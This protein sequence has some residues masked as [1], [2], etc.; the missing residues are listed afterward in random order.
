MKSILNT[1][2][3]AMALLALGGCASTSALTSTE[4]D[5]VYYS[6][7]DRTI[8]NEPVGSTASAQ[9]NT[10]GG[11]SATD[12]ETNPDYASSGNSSSSKSGGSEYYDDDYSYSARIRRFHQ[13]AY[14]SFSYG[15]YD[16]FY[17]DPFW[18]GG[19][20]YS[21]YGGGYSPYGWGPG[22]YGSYYDPFYSP[23]GYG[24]TAVIINIGFGRPYYSPWGYGYGGYGYGRGYYDG[25]RNGLYS[26]YGN[27]YGGT[28]GSSRNVH[29]G[30][31]T[32]RSQEATTDGRAATGVSPGR[33]RTR[34]GGVANSEGGINTTGSGA[35]TSS[36]WNGRGRERSTDNPTGGVSSSSDVRANDVNTGRSRDGS[37]QV[38]R[39]NNTAVFTDENGTR[40]QTRSREGAEQPRTTENAGRRWRTVENTGNADGQPATNPTYPNYSEQR[41]SRSREAYSGDQSN[42]Q[43]NGGQQAEQ[44][45]RRQRTYEA[46]AQQPTRTYEAPQ[47]TYEAPSRSYEPSR[48]TTPAPSMGG[49]SSGGGGGRSSG[50]GGRG[51][52]E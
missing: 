23:Y 11:S 1:V 40:V 49:G 47:R 29:Y 6:S 35:G 37:E 21:Y 28:V 52:G 3:P 7:K 13:P 8:Y 46:P 51:R 18:Y 38:Q 43:N 25:Y 20:A 26:G 32:G 48:S 34:E 19:S 50:G 36:S 33:G 10:S 12:A 22:Y 30:P 44:P 14:R 31:R 41:R 24:N 27:Y 5:G 42:G 4:S 45:A 16:P 39:R 2:L 17:S 9:D 15:Y